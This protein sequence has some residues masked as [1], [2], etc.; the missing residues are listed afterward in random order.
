MS[1]TRVEWDEN[2]RLKV[3][4]KHGV[5]FKIVQ[6]VFY[7]DRFV[8]YR[9]ARYEDEVRERFTG[10]FKGNYYSGIIAPKSSSLVRLITAREAG[11]D[12]TALYIKMKKENYHGSQ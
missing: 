11:S 6:N 2:K 8:N 4:A 1:I 10:E 9:E 3:L 7:G 12:D 5:D